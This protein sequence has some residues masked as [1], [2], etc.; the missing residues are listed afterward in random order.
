LASPFTTILLIGEGSFL[1]QLGTR[2]MHPNRSIWAHLSNEALA[3][4]FARLGLNPLAADLT[5]PFLA[6]MAVANAD[7]IY[8]LAGKRV[9]G[10]PTPEM[11]DLKGLR[12]ILTSLPP[13]SPKRYIYESSLDVY[14]GMAGEVMDEKMICRPKSQTGRIF[15]EAERELLARFSENG[16]PA[17]IL[18]TASL[19]SPMPGIYNQ[20]RSGSYQIPADLPPVLHRIYLEDYLEILLQAM[21]KGR[22]GQIYN[23]TDQEPHTPNDYFKTMA[24][25]LG[26]SSPQ[27]LSPLSSEGPKPRYSNGKLLR[28]FGYSLRFP[29]FREGLAHG[30]QTAQTEA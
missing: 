20:V 30:I 17:M 25:S 4:G 23:I 6:K 10:K 18:R 22:P 8:H 13:G 19:Y 2:L 12:N 26:V 9:H 29:T 16:F 24:A 3:P 14:E 21:E 28:E 1:K 7:I 11:A 15:V 27:P 5:D